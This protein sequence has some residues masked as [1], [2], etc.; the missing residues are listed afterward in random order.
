MFIITSTCTRMNWCQTLSD[1]PQ[2]ANKETEVQSGFVICSQ[3]QHLTPDSL[4]PKPKFYY[5]DHK[6]IFKIQK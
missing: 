3:S 5:L 2:F 6:H 1:R 4:A